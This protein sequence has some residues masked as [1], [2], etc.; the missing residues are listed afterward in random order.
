MM[1]YPAFVSFK[2]WGHLTVNFCYLNTISGF[3]FVLSEAVTS[4]DNKKSLKNPQKNQDQNK[5]KQ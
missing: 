3:L 1:T 2:I 4:A 5:S